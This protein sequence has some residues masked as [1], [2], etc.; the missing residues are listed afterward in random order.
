MADANAT[1]GEMTITL[2]QTE[3]VMRPSYDAIQKMEAQTGSSLLQ[4]A[5]A[6]GDGSITTGDAAIVVA[7]CIRAAGEA[8]GDANAAGVNSARIGR[9]LM[10]VGMLI[11]AKRIELLLFLAATGGYTAS[12]EVKATGNGTAGTPVAE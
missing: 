11:V 1:R 2:D 5:Q 8:N 4:L 7:E 3:F 6:A 9:L 12:G 10:E